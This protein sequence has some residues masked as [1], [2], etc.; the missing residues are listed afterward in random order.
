[1]L[2]VT[3]PTPLHY[4]NGC[5]DTVQ[6]FDG[7]EMRLTGTFAMKMAVREWQCGGAL[8]RVRAGARLQLRVLGQESD[9][10]QQ[11]HCGSWCNSPKNECE[12]QLLEA[13]QKLISWAGS[14]GRGARAAVHQVPS[15]SGQHGHRDQRD[16]GQGDDRRQEAFVPVLGTTL[17]EQR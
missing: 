17:A 13:E 10:P 9:G 3:T 4:N 2:T 8:E 11:D 7:G 15:A 16:H 14:G 5:T 1:M 12:L 6:R